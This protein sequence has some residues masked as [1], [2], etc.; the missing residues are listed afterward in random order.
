VPAGGNVGQCRKNAYPYR[1]LFEKRHDFTPPGTGGRRQG[2]D[3][4]V[5]I[6]TLNQCRQVLGRIHPQTAHVLALQGGIVIQEPGGEEITP[7]S[8]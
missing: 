4:I 2:D 1:V 8:K 5:N 3:H 7:T 6:E